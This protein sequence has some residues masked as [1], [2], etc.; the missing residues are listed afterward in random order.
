MDTR[1]GPA[2][3]GLPRRSSAKPSEVWLIAVRSKSPLAARGLLL[4]QRVRLRALRSTALRRDRWARY[5]LAAIASPA[6]LMLT[7]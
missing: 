1:A 6:G 3:P 2:S 7:G 4:V 5:R